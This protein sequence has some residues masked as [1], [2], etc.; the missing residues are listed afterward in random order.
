MDAADGLRLDGALGVKAVVPGDAPE[1]PS[2]LA[3]GAAADAAPP[4]AASRRAAPRIEPSTPLRK[5]LLKDL[6]PTPAMAPPSAAATSA[7][8]AAPPPTPQSSAILGALFRNLMHT[9][10]GEAVHENART[11]NLMK[12]QQQ[13]AGPGTATAAATWS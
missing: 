13:Q 6:A 10:G 8:G 11:P 9:R 2:A 4:G 1:A 5:Q 3:N 12:L 7:V